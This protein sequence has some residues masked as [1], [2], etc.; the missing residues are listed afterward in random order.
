M[1]YRDTEAE[2]QIIGSLLSEPDCYTEIFDV[3]KPEDFYDHRL[4]EVYR[5]FGEQYETKE[6]TDI[7]TLAK[8]AKVKALTLTECLEK[9]WFTVG[10][11][12]VAKRVADISKKRTIHVRLAE[13]QRDLDTL[14]VAEISAHLSDIASDLVLADAKKMI[15]NTEAALELIRS[16]QIARHQD[17]GYIRG[18]RSGYGPLDSI[19][20]GL[21]PKRMTLLVAPTGF[22]K[23]TLAIN[24]YDNIVKADEP[25][26]FVSNENDVIDNLDRLAALV[27]GL[28]MKDIEGGREHR[29]V[30][31]EMVKRYREK[32]AYI[33]DNSPRTI[34][35]VVGAINRY[36]LRHG[37]RIAFVDYIG[38]VSLSQF[39]IKARETEEARLARWGQRL[40][41]CAKSLNIHIVV[42]AQLN[43]QGNMKG[44]PGKTE[45]QGCFK[46]AQKCHSFLI[47][48]RT[49]CGQ[50]VI[51]VDKNRQGPASVDVAVKFERETQ[52]IT[53]Q[54]FW[55][56]AMKCI[57]PYGGQPMEEVATTEDLDI[58]VEVISNAR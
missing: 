11:K 35:E 14:E 10:V 57:R 13:I 32:K 18:I 28:T 30:I 36:V 38:E 21:R 3:I 55:D 41:E 52:R 37:V 50:D 20:R 49:E 45:L 4:G 2:Q 51:T 5:V 27:T 24:F 6:S 26:L 56:D 19:L 33:T 25:A 46:L 31:D 44:R 17:P 8:K 34:E 53:A 43:R 47:F 1:N 48:W 22:G 58:D 15:Y 54:G 42:L 39:D 9:G 23:S 7:G 29:R 12:G 16:V 40:V